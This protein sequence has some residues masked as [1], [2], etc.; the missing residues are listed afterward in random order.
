MLNLLNWKV[1]KRRHQA[2]RAVYK[3]GVIY[4]SSLHKID[5]FHAWE[6]DGHHTGRRI[7][8]YGAFSQ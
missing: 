2:S 4:A 3:R 1:I 6:V 7:I 8:I 5:F